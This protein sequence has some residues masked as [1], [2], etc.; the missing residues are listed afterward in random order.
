MAE[1]KL[2]G[3]IFDFFAKVSVAAVKLE[4]PLKIGDKIKIKGATTDFEQEVKSMQSHNKPLEEAA[5]GDDVGIKLDARARKG[6]KIYL[7]E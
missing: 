5:A 6:D 7:V 3:T 2:V 4:S 1:E